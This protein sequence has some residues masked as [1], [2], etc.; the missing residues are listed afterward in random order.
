MRG[1]QT[2]HGLDHVCESAI[3]QI[4]LASVPIFVRFMHYTTAWNLSVCYAGCGSIIRAMHLPT[5]SISKAG[6]H[7]AIPR[8]GVGIGC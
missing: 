5:W 2:S 4:H 7:L 6:L 3:P 8:R 1:F